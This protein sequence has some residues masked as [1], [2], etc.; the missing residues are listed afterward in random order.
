MHM[1]LR[2]IFLKGQ[3]PKERLTILYIESYVRQIN[4]L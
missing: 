4:H 3:D 1:L 2:L